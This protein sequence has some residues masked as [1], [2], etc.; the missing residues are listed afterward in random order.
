MHTKDKTSINPEPLTYSIP[1]AGAMAGLAKNG[2]YAA[3]RR[4]EIPVIKFGGKRRVPA[5][6]WRRLLAEGR[7]QD[8]EISAD[9][10]E[11]PR[12]VS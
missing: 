3:A 2:S 5:E 10:V 9:A 11:P 6:R 8:Q 12:R 1:V 4:G 7:E